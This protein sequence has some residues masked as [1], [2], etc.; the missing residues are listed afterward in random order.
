MWSMVCTVGIILIGFFQVDLS[1]SENEVYDVVPEP[2]PVQMKTTDVE[3][4]CPPVVAQTR[5]KGGCDPVSPQLVCRG[6][7]AMTE[8]SL[9][10]VDSRQKSIVPDT[11]VVS[12]IYVMP[13]CIPTV[14]PK[15]AAMPQAASTVTQTRPRGSC[16]SNLLLPVDRSIEPLDDDAPDVLT[17]GREP[18]EIVSE[19]GSDVCVVPDQ[20]PVAVSVKTV[21]A[22]APGRWIT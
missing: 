8:D 12:G 9:A 13:D 21:V 22:K 10:T 18:A 14:V 6:R 11:D 2:F 17:F 1:D 16:S 4:F 20:L 7:D 15:L 19:V 3:S 5:P